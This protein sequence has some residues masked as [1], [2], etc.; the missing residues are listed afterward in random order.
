MSE[1][2]IRFETGGFSS[3]N[4]LRAHQELRELR[5][6]YIWQKKFDVFW[7]DFYCAVYLRN[8]GYSNYLS[9]LFYP[10]YFVGKGFRIILKKMVEFRNFLPHARGIENKSGLNWKGILIHYFFRILFFNPYS[11]VSICIQILHKKIS[12][13]PLGKA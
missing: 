1:S 9:Y 7:D 13:E 4:L 6:I 5:S 3:Q 2:V 10:P 11:I 8:L 12:L